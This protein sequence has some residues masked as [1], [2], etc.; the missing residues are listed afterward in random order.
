MRTLYTKINSEN[1]NDRKF[2]VNLDL[3][4]RSEYRVRVAISSLVFYEW[5]T[6][7]LVSISPLIATGGTKAHK[8]LN[9]EGD[10]HDML[11]ARPSYIGVVWQ[12]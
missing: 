11:Q 4:T 10:H 9:L 7:R 5:P 12:L 8:L 1:W 3:A 2:G 6:Q